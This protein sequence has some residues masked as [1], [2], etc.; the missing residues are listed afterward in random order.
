MQ[1][2]SEM[3]GVRLQHVNLEGTR[4]SVLAEWVL[5]GLNEIRSVKVTGKSQS[6][7]QYLFIVWS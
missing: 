6:M 1:P 5:G 4:N 7:T 2:H 3:L